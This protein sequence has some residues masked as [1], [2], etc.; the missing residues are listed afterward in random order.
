MPI[1]F[2]LH[3]ARPVPVAPA[4]PRWTVGIHRA[5]AWPGWRWLD[6]ALDLNW[7]DE[8]GFVPLLLGLPAV[9]TIVAR[10]LTYAARRRTD[11]EV[12]VYRGDVGGYQPKDAVLVENL[13]SKAAAVERAE[14]LWQ[15]L[16]DHDRLPATTP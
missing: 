7:P 5:G 4:S 12:L 13:P 9:P 10:R 2:T 1:P 6:R 16:S 15:H 8:L 14:Q 11:W 3:P